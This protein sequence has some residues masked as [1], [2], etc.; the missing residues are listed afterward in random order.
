MTKSALFRSFWMAGFESACHINRSG[1][2]LDLI[3]ATQHDRHVDED[4]AALLPWNIRA[5]REGMRWHLIDRG[6]TY[7]FSSL[8]PMLAAA[9]R[10]GIDV[11]WNLCHYGWPD[12]VELMAPAF[13]DRFA[14]YCAAAAR[15]VAEHTDRV[16]FYCPINELSFFAW[17]AGEVGYI[18]PFGRDDGHTVKRQLVR[19]AIAGIEAIWAVDPRARMIQVDPIIHVV[20]P[21][22]RPDL[23]AA[24]ADQRERQFHA[25]SMLSG[26]LE[27]ELGGHPKY[28]DIIGVNYYHANQW[29]HPDVRLR[30]EDTPR[31][32]RWV[33]F[34][35][36]L[37]EVYQRYGR[38]MFIAET[39]H[40]GSGRAR[41]IA[42]ITDEVIA[43]RAAG[44]P[45]EGICLYPIIDRPDW[46]MTEAWHNSGLWDVRKVREGDG[47]RLE[48]VLVEEYAEELR[49]CQSLV[50]AV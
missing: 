49:R 22:D 4:Y 5:V 40:F 30:W 36:L 48:R 47:V 34:S 9:E 10:H 33:P 2:R 37:A 27:P 3:C 26:A 42:E 38:P 8:H 15:C 43:A 28:L 16:P 32:P 7:D 35:E 1:T 13:A 17:A 39:S 24:A 14:R 29:E 11:L 50:G 46:D 44:V 31:D 21:R 23:A 19:A 20:P 6:G 41:W 25:W 45:V 12:D 18:H